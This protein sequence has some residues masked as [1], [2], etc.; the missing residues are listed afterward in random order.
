[1]RLKFLKKYIIATLVI[2]GIMAAT[3]TMYFI[4]EENG[5]KEDFASFSSNIMRYEVDY[6]LQPANNQLY[7]IQI[8][9]EGIET[10]D[11]IYYRNI[12]TLKDSGDKIYR[13]N[14]RTKETELVYVAKYSVE[15]SIIKFT[16]ND[17]KLILIYSDEVV[18][19]DMFTGVENRKPLPDYVH[20]A[21]VGQDILY[22]LEDRSMWRQDIR[23]GNRQCIEDIETT[24]FVAD[25]TYIYYEDSG[26]R[27]GYVSLYNQRTGTITETDVFLQGDF[28]LHGGKII[29]YE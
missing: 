23:T 26:L 8:P 18:V 25:E 11:Y 22:N 9:N 19:V 16:A 12:Q 7:E 13:Y 4:H 17:S 21:V 20:I 27:S 3:L 1:M 10:D 2:V 24:N 6:Q 14:K 15:K 28:Y 5:W 29:M